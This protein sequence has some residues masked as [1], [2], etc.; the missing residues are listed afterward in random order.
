MIEVFLSTFVLKDPWSNIN[1]CGISMCSFI[2]LDNVHLDLIKKFLLDL[3]KISVFQFLQILR[4]NARTYFWKEIKNKFLALKKNNLNLMWST[5]YIGYFPRHLKNQLLNTNLLNWLC[6]LGEI[7]NYLSFGFIL[8]NKNIRRAK[9]P[10]ASSKNSITPQKQFLML[11]N[12]N[13]KQQNL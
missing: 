10:G 13:S 5:T 6:I 9:L 4:V 11:M 3:S 12:T 2:S 7:I 1:S 8:S